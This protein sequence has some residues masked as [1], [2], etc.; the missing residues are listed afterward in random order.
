MS[1]GTKRMSG[2]YE[3]I[4][5]E[6][7]GVDFRQC[8][9]CGETKCLVEHF[10]KNGYNPDGSQAY[11]KD[12]RVCYNLRRGENMNKKR[13]SDFLGGQRRRGEENPELTHQEWKECLIFFSG[14]CAYCGCTTRRGTRMTKDHLHAISAGGATIQSNIVPACSSCNSSKGAEDFRDWFMKQDFFSQERLNRIFKWRTIISQT[15]GGD[16]YERTN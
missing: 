14:E 7:D 8:V 13:H 11:R 9:F 4:D 5:T 6:K 12:C 1:R 3:S 10:A 2:Q 15:E 16:R